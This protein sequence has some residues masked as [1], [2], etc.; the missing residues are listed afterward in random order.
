MTYRDTLVQ[1][2]LDWPALFLNEDDVLDHLFITIGNG[3]HWENGCLVSSHD[4]EA[5]QDQRVMY[6]RK[7]PWD[8]RASEREYRVD[9][10]KFSRQS[11][12]FKLGTGVGRYLYRSFGKNSALCNLPDDIQPDWLAAAKRAME[13]ILSN[14]V[15]FTRDQIPWIDRACLRLKELG[16]PVLFPVED[17]MAHA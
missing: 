7:Y 17:S 13:Y 2:L 15:R 10:L 4:Y 1:C 6:E 11:C 12:Y 5:S 3:Y 14:R 16:A 8:V 9:T